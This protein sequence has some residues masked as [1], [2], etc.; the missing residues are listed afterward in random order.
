MQT[1]DTVCS[2]NGLI[3][4]FVRLLFSFFVTQTACYRYAVYFPIKWNISSADS[5]VFLIEEGLINDQYQLMLVR[6]FSCY[7]LG[8]VIGGGFGVRCVRTYRPNV[9]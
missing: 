4:E 8:V 1:I 3:F 2:V 6:A 5:G 7:L 9:R